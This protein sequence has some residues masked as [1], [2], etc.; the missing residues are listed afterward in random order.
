MSGFFKTHSSQEAEL[1]FKGILEKTG[2]G[3]YLYDSEETGDIPIK[4][5][6]FNS[7][8]AFLPSWMFRSDEIAAMLTGKRIWNVVYK[9]NSDAMM[10]YSAVTV[11]NGMTLPESYSK[12]PHATNEEIP[13]SLRY[14][15]C[16]SALTDKLT[17]RD[18]KFDMKD[19]VGFYFN[20][21]GLPKDGVTMDFPDIDYCLA[22]EWNKIAFDMNQ[23]VELP[24]PAID[25]ALELPIFSVDL[26]EK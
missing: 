1:I 22:Y 21:S 15:I 13:F 2:L 10:G 5:E 17:L 20:S 8:D 26:N 24:R 4:L 25:D 14:L 23:R 16:Q 11:P 6:F 12:H 19:D 18:G 3:S 9:G 7:N